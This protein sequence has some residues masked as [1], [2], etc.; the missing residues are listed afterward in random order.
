MDGWLMSWLEAQQ[1]WLGHE[2]EDIGVLSLCSIN[3]YNNRLDVIYPV[4]HSN[5]SGLDAADQLSLIDSFL[6]LHSYP[7]SSESF[8]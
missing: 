6:R 3:A 4:P 8:F 2:A 5:Y 7:A 1:H